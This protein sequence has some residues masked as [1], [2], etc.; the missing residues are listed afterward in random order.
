M[1]VIYSNAV[2]E[3]YSMQDSRNIHTSGRRTATVQA[4]KSHAPSFPEAMFGDCLQAIFRTRWLEA[5]RFAHASRYQASI[6]FN[7]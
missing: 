5:T 3:K 1:R 7:D 4:V 6:Y 2:A